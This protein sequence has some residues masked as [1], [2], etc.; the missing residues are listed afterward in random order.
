MSK[1]TDCFQIDNTEGSYLAVYDAAREQ[2]TYFATRWGVSSQVG[3]SA[4]RVPLFEFTDVEI[5]DRCVLLLLE[6]ANN[7]GWRRKRAYEDAEMEFERRG[8]RMMTMLSSSD[9]TSSRP[10]GASPWPS[11]SR[12]AASS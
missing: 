4:I 11:Q 3:K 6:A 1:A 10:A 12:W 9:T 2:R 7:L 8:Y 5:H